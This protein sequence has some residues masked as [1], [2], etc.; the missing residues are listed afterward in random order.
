MTFYSAIRQGLLFYMPP[1]KLTAKLARLRCK[2]LIQISENDAFA[3]TWDTKTI[4]KLLH[5]FI[6]ETQTL[7]GAVTHEFLIRM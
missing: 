4:T 5:I 6:A 1:R 7:L 3:H 2:Q